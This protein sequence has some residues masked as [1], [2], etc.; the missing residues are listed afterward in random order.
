MNRKKEYKKCFEISTK[1]RCQDKNETKTNNE[2]TV[3]IKILFLF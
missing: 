3:E 2:I 1:V